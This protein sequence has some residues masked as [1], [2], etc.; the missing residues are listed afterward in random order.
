MACHALEI[1]LKLS[2]LRV[3]LKQIFR[4]QVAIGADLLVKI[5]LEF[6]F[7]LSF[8][9]LLL[10]LSDQVV[11]ELD[12]LEALIVARVG[13]CCLV[14]IVL[15]V[16]L[17]LNIFSLKLLHGQRVG[18]L[19][20]AN[21]GELLVVHLDFVFSFALVLLLS[22]QV[23]IEQLPLVNLRI[24]VLLFVLY[25]L[26]H[27]FLLR[28]VDFQIAVDLFFADVKIVEAGPGGGSLLDDD[29]FLLDKLAVFFLS[30]AQIGHLRILICAL[31]VELGLLASAILL[32]FVDLPLD[33]LELLRSLAVLP[34]DFIQGGTFGDE[35]L[36]GLGESLT[37]IMLVLLKLLGGLRLVVLFLL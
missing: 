19:L 24:D 37:Q 34:L 20:K 6:E 22:D 10:Q 8:E 7:G 26:L 2:D 17:K 1:F 16:A 27:L 9:V 18:L 36:L 32:H 14:S 25:L 33:V 30:L 15:F 31:L 21:L 28:D 35:G 5:K 23:A 12:L 13:C 4:V 11:F 3:G 29:V